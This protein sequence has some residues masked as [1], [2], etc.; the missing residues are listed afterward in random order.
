ME[1]VT[2]VALAPVHSGKTIKTQF[3][4]TDIDAMTKK[5]R[6][7]WVDGEDAQESWFL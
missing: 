5:G 3:Y 6:F 7:Q 4:I 1:T 2:V